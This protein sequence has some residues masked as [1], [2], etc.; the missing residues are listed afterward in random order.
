MAFNPIQIFPNDT[1]ARVAIG[2]DIP[3]NDSAVFKSNYQTKDAIKNNLINYLLTH[4]GERIGNPDFGTGIKNY[5][6][7][8]ITNDNLDFIKEDIQI[9]IDRNFSNIIIKSISIF[10]SLNE[11]ICKYNISIEY[12]VSNTN[13]SDKLILGFS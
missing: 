3:F 1:R 8:Q 5:L 10:Q 7:S 9:R 4:T 13:I 2:V 6:F 11:D 12:E